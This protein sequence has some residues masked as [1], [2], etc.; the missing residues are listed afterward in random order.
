MTASEASDRVEAGVSQ[1]FRGVW[2]AVA[3]IVT[4][5]PTRRRNVPTYV[6][7]KSRIAFHCSLGSMR[8]SLVMA[9]ATVFTVVNRGRVMKTFVMFVFV[10]LFAMPCYGQISFG[11]RSRQP[12]ADPDNPYGGL[13]DAAA[14]E[15]LEPANV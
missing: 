14:P 12:S 11:G 15:A 10:L 6:P 5:P 1:V 9:F 8:Y 2:S 4:R 7:P 13:P 3:R